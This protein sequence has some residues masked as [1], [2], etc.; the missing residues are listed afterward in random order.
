MELRLEKVFEQEA[1]KVINIVASYFGIDILLC[2]RCS[3][4][5]FT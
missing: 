3:S 4:I 5:S 2:I 1:C